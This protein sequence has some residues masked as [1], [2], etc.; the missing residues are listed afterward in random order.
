MSAL[1]TTRYS[2]STQNVIPAG[3]SRKVFHRNAQFLYI[4]T[5]ERHWIHFHSGFRSCKWSFA[6]PEP[7]SVG[8]EWRGLGTVLL[9]LNEPRYTAIA[10]VLC[11]GQLCLSVK[12]CSGLAE[13]VHRMNAWTNDLK[14]FSSCQILL[15][16]GIQETHQEMRMR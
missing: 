1:L 8:L 11:D 3:R 16:Y 7:A 13:S 5:Q 9:T 12:R 10:A 14:V 15:C 6:A 4:D 2:Q